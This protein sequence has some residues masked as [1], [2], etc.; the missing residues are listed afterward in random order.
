MIQTTQDFENSFRQNVEYVYNLMEFDNIVL[1]SAIDSLVEMKKKLKENH[2]D[3]PLIVVEGTLK[4]LQQIRNNGSL[5]P[6]YETIY[7]QCIVLLVSYFDSTVGDAFRY[8]LTARLKH[9]VDDRIADEEIKISLR[10]LEASDFSL[11]GSIGNIIVREKKISFQDMKS[12]ARAFEYYFGIQ[13]EQDATVN[14]IVLGQAC[15]HAIVHR[16]NSVDEI[17]LKQV[18]NAHP[19][20]IKEEML[21]RDKIQFTPEEIQKVGESMKSYISSLLNKLEIKCDQ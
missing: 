16:G 21:N 5:R 8:F 2:F 7:N 9:G 19:R 18:Y 17:L 3:N 14:N 12:I 6:K 20:N 4:S 1:K 11:A 13:I 15:R 10:D